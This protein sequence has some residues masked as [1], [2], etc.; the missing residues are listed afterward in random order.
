MGLRCGPEK[1]YI[2]KSIP[3]VKSRARKK[4]RE[5][6]NGLSI[7]LRVSKL[8]MKWENGSEVKAPRSKHPS[9]HGRQQG[10]EEA[11]PPKPK[12]L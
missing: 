6:E 4:H 1:Y 7:E 9:T 11:P 5:E 2:I 3:F 10:E 12:T 8:S